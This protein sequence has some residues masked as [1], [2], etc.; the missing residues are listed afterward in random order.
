VSYT[1]KGDN[2]VSED[3]DQGENSIRES[4]GSEEKAAEKKGQGTA[5]TRRISASI[6]GTQLDLSH[7]KKERSRA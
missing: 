4:F 2:G 5:G 6:F 3:I 1:K 7:E